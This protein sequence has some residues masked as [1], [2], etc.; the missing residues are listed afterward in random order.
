MCLWSCAVRRN[1]ASRQ[2]TLPHTHSV[3]GVVGVGRP[4]SRLIKS[5]GDRG[6]VGCLPAC[7]PA[8]VPAIF[9]SP[10]L[11]MAVQLPSQIQIPARDTDIYNCHSCLLKC[12][13]PS[14]QPNNFFLGSGLKLF[15]L[16]SVMTRSPPILSS[17][18]WKVY[19]FLGLI[20]ID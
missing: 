8:S 12:E 2:D 18:I 10:A 1:Q 20:L 7:L 17:F 14:E 19:Q 3:R 15:P 16:F 6:R 5:S 9:R 4:S 11:L 13:T